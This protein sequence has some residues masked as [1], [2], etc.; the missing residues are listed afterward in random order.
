MRQLSESY[1]IKTAANLEHTSDN[2]EQIWSLTKMRSCPAFG[3]ACFFLILGIMGTRL[4]QAASLTAWNDES[5][6]TFHYEA[7][8]GRHTRISSGQQPDRHQQSSAN[9]YWYSESDKAPTIT[10]CGNDLHIEQVAQNELVVLISSYIQSNTICYQLLPF[11]PEGHVKLHGIPSDWGT[12]SYIDA[13]EVEADC[14][15]HFHFVTDDKALE[16]QVI[17]ETPQSKSVSAAS[18]YSRVGLPDIQPGTQPRYLDNILMAGDGGDSGDFPDHPRRPGYF[19]HSNAA[20]LVSLLGINTLPPF[21]EWLGNLTHHLWRVVFGQNVEKGFD[22]PVV[23]V[24]FIYS[25]LEQLSLPVSVE[26]SVCDGSTV[27]GILE[28]GK[29]KGQGQGGSSG[30]AS[31]SNGEKKETKSS[32]TVAGMG[33]VTI[34][35]SGGN[36]GAG[37]EQSPIGGKSAAFNSVTEELNLVEILASMSGFNWLQ[38]NSILMALYGVGFLG[39]SEAV[40]LEQGGKTARIAKIKERAATIKDTSEKILFLQLIYYHMKSSLFNI[41]YL[42]G[43]MKSIPQAYHER[44][45]QP[46]QLN[47][48]FP[49]DEEAALEALRKLTSMAFLN[50]LMIDRL[51]MLFVGE[52]RDGNILKYLTI[53]HSQ[54]IAGYRKLYR[55]QYFRELYETHLPSCFIDC[56][57]WN[58]SPWP[59][60]E[61]LIIDS[62]AMAMAMPGLSTLDSWGTFLLEAYGNSAITLHQFKR[63]VA[64]PDINRYEALQEVTATLDKR[65]A[66]RFLWTLNRVLR[67]QHPKLA[68]RFYQQVSEGVR[69]ILDSDIEALPLPEETGEGDHWRRAF[70]ASLSHYLNENSM[71]LLNKNLIINKV[72]DPE[73]EVYLN[74]PLIEIKCSQVLDLLWEFPIGSSCHDMGVMRAISNPVGLRTYQSVLASLAANRLSLL[75]RR[76]KEPQAES[77]KSAAKKSKLS[78]PCPICREDMSTCGTVSCKKC[79]NGMCLTCG[80]KLCKEEQGLCPYCKKNKLSIPRQFQN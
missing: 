31:S 73:V 44:V 25:F 77:G 74:Q 18:N 7:E 23:D 35:N 1:I 48:P 8:T 56:L 29:S 42:P 65:R 40:V 12:G 51:Q 49:Q 39:F 16:R 47:I 72:V 3:L 32:A 33:S 30:E 27:P 26:T 78:V 22:N 79:E 17:E 61:W 59:E 63:L 68:E 2:T 19:D 75:S 52:V 46:F 21:S 67:K 6:L 53:C 45:K 71:K 62:A 76:Q 38:H 10:L 69:S 11:K 9:L 41:G 43:F 50:G 28:L 80:E 60:P 4:I 13:S 64:L 34:Q 57:Q 14:L 54:G 24:P 58:T 66:A 70:A 5:S 36:G 20:L 15:V 55:V 37:G